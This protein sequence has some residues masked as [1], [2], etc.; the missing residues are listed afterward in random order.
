M[1]SI[2]KYT[3]NDIHTLCLHA[4]IKAKQLTGSKV[5]GFCTACFSVEKTSM[6]PS[7]SY[8]QYQ[9]VEID[10]LFFCLTG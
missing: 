1:A 8:L 2:Q 10:F 3:Q 7:F 6:A 4:N 5:L 9:F